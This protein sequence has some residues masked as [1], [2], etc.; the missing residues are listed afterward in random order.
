MRQIKFNF[1]LCRHR[2]NVA[3]KRITIKIE[4]V[5]LRLISK[6]II[7]WIVEARGRRIRIRYDSFYRRACNIPTFIGS[8][9]VARMADAIHKHT[10]SKVPPFGTISMKPLILPIHGMCI[11]WVRAR[12]PLSF[13][14]STTFNGCRLY[15]PS[16]SKR[17]TNKHI[18]FDSPTLQCRSCHHVRFRFGRWSYIPLTLGAFPIKNCKRRNKMAARWCAGFFI[19]TLENYDFYE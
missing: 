15:G 11:V 19:R 5:F 13:G 7:K 18:H 14:H 16:F 10:R 8:N 4:W 2:C 12:T 9:T 1:R 17:Q 6:I 3:R